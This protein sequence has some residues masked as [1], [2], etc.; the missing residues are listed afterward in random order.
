MDKPLPFLPLFCRRCRCRFKYTVAGG[1]PKIAVDR[2]GWRAY[3]VGLMFM[4][5]SVT[6]W[7][8][9]SM[10]AL[11]GLPGGLVCLGQDGHIGIAESVPDCCHDSAHP[12][13]DYQAEPDSPGD[14]CVDIVVPSID[15]SVK[16]VRRT[17]TASTSRPAPAWAAAGPIAPTA[18]RTAASTVACDAT[19]VDGAPPPFLRTTVLLL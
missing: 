8:V 3:N 19:R 4:R 11:S 5:R 16:K 17:D 9:V 6:C 13:P 1:L 15:A 12:E 10:L 18:C 2:F 7:L 14:C